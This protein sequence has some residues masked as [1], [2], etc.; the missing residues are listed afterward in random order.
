MTRGQVSYLP[1]HWILEMS[2]IAPPTASKRDGGCTGV[3]VCVCVCVC[4]SVCLCCALIVIQLG[5][6]SY[7]TYTHTQRQKLKRSQS[8]TQQVCPWKFNRST[9][10]N[11]HWRQPFCLPETGD[12]IEMLKSSFTSQ[13]GTLQSSLVTSPLKRRVNRVMNCRFL[14]CPLHDITATTITPS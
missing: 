3:Y 13:N 14:P 5:K 12:N 1:P 2:L 9:I 7:C 6:K 4:V 8:D 10:P 11:K